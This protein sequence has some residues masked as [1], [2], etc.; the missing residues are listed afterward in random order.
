ME[1]PS[2]LGS[3][4]QKPLSAH[5]TTGRFPCHEFMNPLL[6]IPYTIEEHLLFISLGWEMKIGR[7]HV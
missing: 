4:G 1:V 5:D 2:V 6:P 3:Q 7:A